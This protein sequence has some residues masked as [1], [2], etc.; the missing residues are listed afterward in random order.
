MQKVSN[1]DFFFPQKSSFFFPLYNFF[2]FH[3][4]SCEICLLSIDS[5]PV[6]CYLEIVSGDQLCD[7]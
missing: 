5:L 7:L 3:E 2:L 6:F 4:G 1:Y